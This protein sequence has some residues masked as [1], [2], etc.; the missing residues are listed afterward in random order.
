MFSPSAFASREKRPPLL[1]HARDAHSIELWGGVLV[2]GA[3]VPQ[4]TLDGRYF[5]SHRS[6]TLLNLSVALGLV[7]D[8]LP[9]NFRHNLGHDVNREQ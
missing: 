7:V 9:N 4:T 8:V 2:E 5:R 3:V 1:A 6:P